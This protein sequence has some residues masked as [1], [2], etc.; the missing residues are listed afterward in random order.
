MASVVRNAPSRVGVYATQAAPGASSTALNFLAH[1]SC[2]TI[3]RP[4]A[5]LA[6][7]LGVGKGLFFVGDT[8]I[9]PFSTS[10]TRGG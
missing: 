6:D 2:A 8:P 5:R 3:T 7:S 4:L 1:A 9:G 10:P